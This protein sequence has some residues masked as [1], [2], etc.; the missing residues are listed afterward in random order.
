MILQPERHAHHT[1]QRFD[2]SPTT[3]Q[4]LGAFDIICLVLNRTIGSGIFTVPPKVLAGTG[5][6]G[7]SLLLWLFGGII[8]LCAVLCWLELGLTI[9]MHTLIERGRPVRVSAPRSGGEKNYLEYIFKNPPFLM[10]AIFGIM[11]IVLGNLAGNAVAFGFNVMIAAGKDPINS[12]ANN[13][14]KGPV[15][16]LAITCVTL[17]CLF[18]VFS[19]RGGI[20]VN[21][22]FAVAKVGILLVIIVL[23][24]VHAGGKYLRTTSNFAAATSFRS[25]HDFSS[26]VGSLLVAVYPYTG[27]EQ[28]FYVLSEVAT[29]KKVFPKAAITAM[30]VTIAL[31]MLVNIS[32]FCVVPKETY[33]EVPGIEIDMASVFLHDLF[34]STLG[35]HG[36]KRAMAALVAFSIFGNILV[37]TFT[38]ARVKQEIAKE[39]IIP[40]SLFFATG[41]TT[42]WARFRNRN[43]RRPD[44]AVEDD[45]D[46]ETHLEQS[47]MAA[48]GLH[49]LSTV[50]LILIT[51]MLNPATAYSILI[52]LYSY[53]NV[54]V[55]GSLT[56]GGL[57]YLKIDSWFR[58][59]NGRN[60]FNKTQWIPYLDPLPA[61]IYFVSM[62]F[63]L[64][65][66]FVKP[67][68]DSPF[69]QDSTGYPWFLVPAIGL[70]SLLWGVVWWL[71]LE[72]AQWSGHF[73]I[74]VTRRP[75]L[76]KDGEGNYV[77]VVELVEHQRLYERQSYVADPETP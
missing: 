70:T 61:I 26:F 31:Y 65:A 72:F 21:N 27:F 30:L 45:L 15:I 43:R 17:C 40:K 57:L 2:L 46:L 3:T 66:L 11:F 44:A 42:P 4:L 47:P 69:S 39:G 28:P 32:F 23:G 75:Y 25:K 53:V 59:E 13:Y 76:V 34:D 52:T 77:Q 71:G 24:F 33:T 5:S 41:H 58:G 55:L 20:I 36:A 67:A 56:G 64:F 8:I 51:A 68:A 49:W 19:R 62:T 63:F 6:I 12:N 14:E 48:L 60:W 10:T 38:A 50:F 18:H 29:P 35:P 22:A 1:F 54:S 74:L 9:P 73:R 37:L 7:A 16:G